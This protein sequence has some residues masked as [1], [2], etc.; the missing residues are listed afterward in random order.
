MN[1]A[2]VRSMRLW[3]PLLIGAAYYN[4]GPLVDRFLASGL[5]TGNISH[6]AYASRLIL[7]MMALSV[8]SLSTVMFPVL[9]QH[10]S[11]GETEGLFAAEVTRSIRFLSFLLLPLAV[12]LVCFSQPLVHDL[13]ER[14]KFEPYDTMAVGQLVTLYVGMLLGAS[15]VEITA[16]AFFALHDARTPVLIGVAAFTLGTVLKVVLCKTHGLPG[17]SVATSLYYLLNAVVLLGLLYHRLQG[18]PVRDAIVGVARSLVASTVTALAAW[19]VLQW[20]IPYSAIMA[21]TIGAI[22]YV[23]I[24]SMLRDE[25]ARSLVRA[26]VGWGAKQDRSS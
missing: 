14:G 19:L 23:A 25:F 13:F 9:A 8:N 24:A 5:P 3:V 6:L 11:S 16:R 26:A 18:F 17:I 7:A 21:A 10:K 20:N 2:L 12:G 4:L 22:V 15:L 1:D